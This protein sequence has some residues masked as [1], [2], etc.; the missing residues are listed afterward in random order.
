[1]IDDVLVEAPLLL[2]LT[3]LQTQIGEQIYHRFRPGGV[4]AN[5]A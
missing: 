2:V 3:Y 5:K 4:H 1:V